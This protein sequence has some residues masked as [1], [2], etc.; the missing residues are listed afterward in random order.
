MR[1]PHTRTN[2]Y[3]QVAAHVDI[4]PVRVHNFPTSESNINDKSLARASRPAGEGGYDFC[5]DPSMQE[6]Y[7]VGLGVRVRWWVRNNFPPFPSNSSVVAGRGMLISA[8]STGIVGF[9][10]R[11]PPLVHSGYGHPHFLGCSPTFYPG[12][13]SRIGKGTQHFLS[14]MILVNSLPLSYL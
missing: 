8:F 14:G 7:P 12:L 2:K 3:K 13:R 1:L 9:H 6:T 10:H 4:V 5:Q 11:N